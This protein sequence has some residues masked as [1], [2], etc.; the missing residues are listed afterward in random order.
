MRIAFST[1]GCPDFDW[2]DI[3]TMAKDLQFDGIEVRGIGRN[4]HAVTAAPFTPRRIN[5]TIQKLSDLRLTIP[6][7]SSNT[8][9][10][11]EEDREAAVLEITEYIEL[12]HEL[13]TPYIRVLADRDA[14]PEGEVDDDKIAEALLQLADIAKG[15]NVTLLVETNGVY[16][17]TARLRKLLDRV[18]RPE[19]AALWDIHHPYRYFGES[20]KTTVD[21]LGPYIRHVHA[22]GLRGGKRP[23]RLQ[24]DGRGRPARLRHARRAH[25]HRL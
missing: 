15:K 6:C 14:A 8:A 25:R 18:N 13:G 7:F 23:H 16:G 1:L 4:I 9:L 20:P 10:K 5:Q 24:D 21:N 12:A 22:K 19:I 17:D 3:Y 2:V 11:D